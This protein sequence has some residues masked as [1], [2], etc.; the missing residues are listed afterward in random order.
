MDRTSCALSSS[1]SRAIHIL[2]R[3]SLSSSTVGETDTVCRCLSFSKVREGALPTVALQSKA[4]YLNLFDSL[5]GRR[6]YS[7]R[8]END[9]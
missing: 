6:V 3:R 9:D 1:S 5:Q 7:R 4:S 8:E 2:N